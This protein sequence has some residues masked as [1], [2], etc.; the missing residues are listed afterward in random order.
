[1]FE[2]SF[3]ISITAHQKQKKGGKNYG[4]GGRHVERHK[5]KD[6]RHKFLSLLGAATHNPQS[7]HHKDSA[8]VDGT[9]EESTDFFPLKSTLIILHEIKTR[10]LFYVHILHQNQSAPTQTKCY[11]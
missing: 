10:R 1:M 6:L 5:L 11:T 2:I 4:K 8:R 9:M 7:A 3:Q